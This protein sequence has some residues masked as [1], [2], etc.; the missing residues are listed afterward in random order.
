QDLSR[1]DL[2]L[3]QLDVDNVTV[4]GRP[5]RFARDGQELQITP[6]NGIREGRAF[7]VT[8]RYGGVPQT[9]VGSPIVF[10]SPYGFLHTDDGAFMGDEPNV[11]STWFPVSDHPRDKASYTFRVSVPKGLGVVANGTLAYHLDIGSRSLWVWNEPLPMASYLVTADIGHWNV[12]Q[13][14][15]PGGIPEY[16]AVDPVLPDVTTTE[17]GVT[18]TRTA[19]DFFYE[20]SARAADLWTKLFGPYPFDVVGAIADNATY[21]GAPLGFSL[22]TQTKPVYSAVR[23]SNT[24]AHELSHQWFGD[25]VSVYSWN[26][27]WLNEG[28]ATFAEYLWGEETGVR[29]AHDAFLAD[30]SRPASSS[31]W[32]L[33]IS[34][35]QRDTMFGNAVYRRGGMT[36]QAL[37]EK[38]GNDD[39][40]FRILQTWTAQHRYGNATTQDFIALAERISGLDLDDFFHVWLD[41]PAK[42]ITW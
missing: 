22:E 16:V 42:P 41:V 18:T 39:T 3:Q 8:V 20:Y 5:A 9:V 6:R 29:S 15:T 24:I 17:R 23:S 36:L 32:Q 40:F 27:I 21:D 37:R 34:D 13:G 33:V 28:F 7:V 30:Y 1:F 11:A 14:R 10:G 35:P 2:D 26:N 19:V 4:D 38:I 25:S 12:R 31:F